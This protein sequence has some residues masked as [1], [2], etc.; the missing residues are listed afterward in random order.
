MALQPDKVQPF[1]PFAS[2]GPQKRATEIVDDRRKFYGSLSGVIQ[3]NEVLLIPSGAWPDI[4]VNAPQ[5]QEALR[6]TLAR[7]E[8]VTLY[9]HPWQNV[10]DRFRRSIKFFAHASAPGVP[11]F[12]SLQGRIFVEWGV[13][14]ARNFTYCDLAPGSLHI[15]SAQWVAV[16]G[17][18]HTDTMTRLAVS[19]QLGYS[20]SKSDA[21]WTAIFW[22]NAIGG[23]TVEAPNFARELTGYMQSTDP[24]AEA[25][26]AHQQAFAPPAQQWL[27]RPAI[28]P[29]PQAIPFPPVK[30]PISVGYIVA[31]NILNPGPTLAFAV[32]GAGLT[33]RI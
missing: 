3:G 1:R 23:Y 5:L 6:L 8:P 13:G 31:L 7:P 27:L 14:A 26:I 2:G 11:A 16:S 25:T 30:V 18:I 20:H 9:F 28:T 32:V 33:V 17:W 12:E 10:G 21:I 24:L 29:N 19:A 4:R 15:P 22:H